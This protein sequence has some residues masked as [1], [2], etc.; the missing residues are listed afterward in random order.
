[1]KKSL[2]TFAHSRRILQPFVKDYKC[3]WFDGGCFI[4]A[5]ALQIWLGGRLA[6]IV[7]RELLDEQTFDH[8]VLS[9]AD[10]R[11]ETQSL[12]IDANGV[13]SG[14][15]LLHYWRT[16]EALSNPVLEDP[17]NR[18]RL[19]SP[20]EEE[21]WSKWLAEQMM[22]RFGK[23]GRDDLFRILGSTHSPQVNAAQH[24]I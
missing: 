20:L 6:V 5:R 3:G 4:F 1:M 7:R 12:Y 24:V 19:I 8:C 14:E 11:R 17:V 15:D 23:P 21:A 13:A 9:V 18:I 10:P 22:A 16:G 2:H